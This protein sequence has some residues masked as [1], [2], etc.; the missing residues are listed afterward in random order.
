MRR[1]HARMTIGE[2]HASTPRWHVTIGRVSR[3]LADWWSLDRPDTWQRLTGLA[4][5]T[6]LLGHALGAA[7]VEAFLFLTL[8]LG[9]CLMGTLGPRLLRRSRQTGSETA[10][11]AILGF[12]LAWA[13]AELIL[14]PSSL[15]GPT[16]LA[17]PGP[18]RAGLGI[19]AVLAL[20]G[21]SPTP[22]LGRWR[23]PLLLA[24]FAGVG[25]WVIA[26]TPNPT[27]DVFVFQQDA[28]RALAHGVNPY[29]IDFPNPSGRLDFY[30]PG[31]AVDGRLLFGFPYPP[32]SLL[33]TAP[34][35]L[36]LGDHRYAQLTAVTIAG[37]LLAYAR[38]GRLAST[39][40]ALL[41]FTPS[42]FHI[43]QKAWTEPFAVLLMALVVFCACRVPR[44][45]G[46]ALGLLL[47]VKQYLLLMVPL[48]LLLA[49]RRTPRAFLRE[50]ILPAVVTAL[51]VTVPLAAWDLPAFMHSVVMLQFEQPFRIDSLSY[52]AL[53]AIV[54][55]TQPS[56]LIA[57]VAFG[58][59]ALLAL[60]RAPRTASGF[61]AA[62]ALCFLVFFA[63]SK[64]AFWG[65]YLF[66]IGCLCAA[67]AA[68][69]PVPQD[70]QGPPATSATPPPVSADGP[71]ME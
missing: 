33:L 7:R 59:M 69:L 52:A 68:A 51:V 67:I 24:V 1:R 62:T 54:S 61:A 11:L 38:P 4:L 19:A 44:A 45:L 41:L 71:R 48:A 42:M 14:E 65:Y 36:L 21:L 50:L 49:G 26:M 39:A 15:V 27:I 37:A 28:S 22:W 63:S 2:G 25:A 29:A 20:A 35:E 30:A 47:A 16:D 70:R 23:M 53:I 66:V 31:L 10:V 43:I 57:I 6:V 34:A 5:A 13:F 18:V 46:V 40:A 17:D 60:W 32:L 56:A 8:A 64:Q 9:A 12:G 3:R 58:V 55:G